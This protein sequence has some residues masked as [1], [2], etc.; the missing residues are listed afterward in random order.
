MTIS[1]TVI[2]LDNSQ[3]TSSTMSGGVVCLKNGASTSEVTFDGTD[4]E[5]NDT[6]CNSITNNL[7]VSVEEEDS[8]SESSDSDDEVDVKVLINLEIKYEIEITDFENNDYK[9]VFI[10]LIKALFEA[11]QKIE[12]VIHRLEEGST[13]VHGDVRTT[14]PL[15]EAKDAISTMD[16]ADDEDIAIAGVSPSYV[17][18]YEPKQSNRYGGKT[19]HGAL[20]YGLPLVFIGGLIFCGIIY[21]AEKRAV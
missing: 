9:A 17:K 20:K 14:S 19:N 21:I 11:P 6:I 7:C 12:V 10:S 18:Y 15:V 3:L 5:G 8:D 13:I 2:I 4:Q 1:D 16:N